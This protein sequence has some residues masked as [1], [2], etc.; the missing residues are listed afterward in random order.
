MKIKHIRIISV[1]LFVIV[2]IWVIFLNQN[3]QKKDELSQVQKKLQDLQM[4]NEV[5]ANLPDSVLEDLCNKVSGKKY[6]MGEISTLENNDFIFWIK[7]GDEAERIDSYYIHNFN[8]N[9]LTHANDV[10]ECGWDANELTLESIRCITFC[11]D[12]E[13]EEEASN[14]RLQSV[15][16]GTY[17][18]E[19]PD[20][21]G[22]HRNATVVLVSGF[23]YAR[24][25][26]GLI[27]SI[28]YEYQ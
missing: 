20:L 18:I 27:E 22:L 8:N 21:K 3:N 7:Y 13:C 17:K 6:S 14:T 1:F 25:E 28:H 11:K 10:I 26:T 12:N 15:G 9:F 16:I 24:G 4:S 5:I 19:I 2:C 23:I